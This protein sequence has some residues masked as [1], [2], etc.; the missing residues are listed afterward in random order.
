MKSSEPYKHGVDLA[1]HD[2]RATSALGAPVKPGWF[3]TGSIKLTGSSGFADLSFP[4]RGQ[5]HKGTVYVVARKF[6]GKWSYQ[7]IVLHV[8]GTEE[9]IDVLHHAVNPT[10]EN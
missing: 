8:D 9:W 4:V 3:V 1:T 10:A 7:R 6:A 2:P 5:L